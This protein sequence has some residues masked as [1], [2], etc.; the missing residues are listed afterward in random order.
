MP[1]TLIHRLMSYSKNENRRGGIS[2]MECR[3]SME[4]MLPSPSTKLTTHPK[5]LNQFYPPRNFASLLPC[6]IENPPLSTPLTT[7]WMTSPTEYSKTLRCQLLKIQLHYIPPP[8][9]HLT[10]VRKLIPRKH[11]GTAR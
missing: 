9:R 7:V 4:A 6:N 8:P 5:R 1:L 2:D 10:W 3:S 11:E